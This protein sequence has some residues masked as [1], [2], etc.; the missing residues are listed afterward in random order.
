V[1]ATALGPALGA[2]DPSEGNAPRLV[3]GGIVAHNDE[4]RIE[5]SIRSLLDQELPADYRWSGIWV[6][7]SGCTDRTVEI[8]RS[9]AAESPLLTLVVEE[10]RR[11]K[12]AALNEV[13]RRAE[14]EH[15][16]FLNGDAKARPR[17]VA[18][19]LARARGLAPPFAVMGC[20][21][22]PPEVDGR[23]GRTLGWMWRL[24]HEFHADTLRMGRG[25]HLSDELLLVSLPAT[26]RVPVGVINDGAYLA[27]WLRQHGGSCWYAPGA[28]SVIDVPRSVSDHL[29][30][31]RRIH[32]GNAQ[33]ASLLGTPPA[34][35]PGLFLREPRRALSLLR[36]V[37][38]DRSDLEAFLRIVLLE[39]AALL[40]AGWD[41]VPPRRDHVRWSRIGRRPSPHRDPSTARAPREVEAQVHRLLR[42][43][44][45]FGSGLPLEHLVAL[46][47]DGSPGDPETLRS[48]LRERPSLATIHDDEVFL[49]D[50]R[51]RAPAEAWDRRR[52]A[53]EY[54]REAERVL[55]GPLRPTHGLLRC[56]AVTGSTAYGYP[57]AGDDLDFFAVTRSGAL[58]CFLAY[59]YLALRR[60]SADAAQP[61]APCFN[62]VVDEVRART[63]FA[64]EHDRLFAREALTARV[65]LGQEYYRGLLG[66]APWMAREFP[67]L[68]ADRASRHGSIPDVPAPL[69]VRA[70]NLAIFPL[71]ATYLQLVTLYRNA[72]L[73]R[74]GRAAAAF[75]ADTRPGRL[76]FLSRRFEEIRHGY[77]TAELPAPTDVARAEESLPS[78]VGGSV[79]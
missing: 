56:L 45:R 26:P 42:V 76:A 49:P 19:L 53:S 28:Q 40:L 14:G 21:S 79:A 48:F 69:P 59:T 29:A 9:I 8:V 13:I 22:L 63:E 50:S 71:L 1:G 16:V 57:R 38:R 32:V 37:T 24:H 20:P 11:G 3:A 27:V 77:A 67:R 61:P 7:T 46:L 35:M 34:S 18:E 78:S 74:S 51:P 39:G 55:E 43:A 4:Q 33:V 17:A 60:R 30:Q 44:H 47:P 58:W 52:R 6:V 12:A 72:R 68:Y 25:T 70:L 75:R 66:R 36:R 31:R 23:W 62:Y 54:E 65:L 73:R 2:T 5:S 10:E 64:E 15:L 41:R